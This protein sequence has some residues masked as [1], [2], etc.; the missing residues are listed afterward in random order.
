[1]S[2]DKEHIQKEE[3]QWRKIIAVGNQDAGM[4]LIYDQKLCAFAHEIGAALEK[5]ITFDYIFAASRLIERINVLLS[6]LPKEKFETVVGIFLN[7]KQRL[8][9]EVIQ[10]KT[11][12]RKKALNSFPEEI[13]QASHKLCDELEKR[14]CK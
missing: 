12:Q 8:K 10:G 3:E 5:K 1:M 6:K 14:F 13:H 4:V 7:I 9:E 2:I 11:A